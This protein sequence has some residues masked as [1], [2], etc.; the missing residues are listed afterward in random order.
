MTP[1]EKT[2]VVVVGGG[3]AGAVAAY[4]AAE[5]GLRVVLLEAKTQAGTPCHCAEWVPALLAG[6]VDLPGR[7]RRCRLNALE[8]EVGSERARAEVAGY[9]ID[10]P[11][12]EQCLLARAARAGAEIWTGLRMTGLSERGIEYAGPGGTGRIEAEAVIA[13]DGARSRVAAALDLEPLPT[14]PGLQ[15]EVDLKDRAAQGLARFSPEL[16][17]YMWLFPKGETANLGL[18]GSVLTGHGL[19]RLLDWWRSEL[20]DRGII[21]R[22]VLRRSAGLI[23]VG[24]PRPQVAFETGDN[25]FP[26]VLLAGDAAGLTHPVTGAGI[27]QAVISGRLAGQAVVDRLIQGRAQAWS[28]YTDELTGRW[29]GYLRRGL[30]RREKA[31]AGWLDRFETV[32]KEFWTLWPK[33]RAKQAA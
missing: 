2:Q 25:D 31:E 8:T 5:G 24:G 9:V 7:V 20:I 16:F 23:P 13:A 3:P 21:G 4:Q 19:P 30:A 29:G 22:S 1:P 28:D 27:P 15:W 14:V 26:A 10:R 32:V 18:G 6:E 12:W 11:S 17:G 33:K